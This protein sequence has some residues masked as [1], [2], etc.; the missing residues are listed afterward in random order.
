MDQN[1][2]LIEAFGR[3]HGLVHRVVEGATDEQLTYRPDA[4]ANSV[5]WLVWH[6]TRVMDDHVSELAGSDQEWTAAGWA[7]RFGLPFHPDETGYGHSSEKVGQVR[8]SGDLLIGY[9]DAVQE[10]SVA[11]LRG[12]DPQA[13]DRIIDRSWDPPVSAGVR[14]VSVIGDSMQ[15]IGQAAYVLGMESR[16]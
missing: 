1:D 16:R 5:A 8:A 4:D 14:L 3:I 11:Y 7:D 10:A 13:L 2:I 15:H 6:L 9:H 12:L